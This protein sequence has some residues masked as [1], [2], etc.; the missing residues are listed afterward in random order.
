[1]LVR[2]ALAVVVRVDECVR[3]DASEGEGDAL[4]VKRVRVRDPF[5]CERCVEFAAVF[6]AED[7]RFFVGREPERY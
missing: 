6:E 2:I 3:T 5:L 4:S 1:M 7:A